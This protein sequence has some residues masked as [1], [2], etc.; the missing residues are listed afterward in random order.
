MNQ[1]NPK[2]II[3]EK[4]TQK[5]T[6]LHRSTDVEWSGILLYSVLEGDIK[7]PET[8]VLKA[9]DFYLMN[10]G[11]HSYTEFSAG[12]EIVNVYD[13]YLRLDPDEAEK[14][15]QPK[16]NMGLIHTHHGMNCFFSGTDTQ[17][18]ED[19]T[20]NYLFYLSLIVNY[21][22]QYVAKIAHQVKETGKVISRKTKLMKDNN[23]SWFEFDFI[24]KEEDL[25][26]ES[27]VSYDC[28]LLFENCL[29]LH[30]RK[31]ELLKRL[32]D[33]NPKWGESSWVRFGAVDDKR[34]GL[35]DPNSFFRKTVN[36]KTIFDDI[37]FE[38]QTSLP[39]EF[40]MSETVVTAIIKEVLNINEVRNPQTY[41]LHY[42]FRI[43]DSIK[44]SNKTL[45]NEW[46]SCLE[47]NLDLAIE[48]RVG[49]DLTVSETVEFFKICKSIVDKKDYTREYK[50]ADEFVEFINEMIEYNGSKQK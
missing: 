8:L 28:N 18:L 40:K 30:N 50:S 24:T 21:K 14:L 5:V 1:L 29:D 41:P 6:Y 13:A 10:I 46:E 47:F 2:L 37:D 16:L 12:A 27:V 25:S 11:S 45:Y 38:R 31:E 32:E 7:N 43:I 49:R 15:N 23:G 4:L 17:E 48:E 35:I 19:N 34:S 26:N 36:T 42:Y 20:K 39:L 3:S 22:G 9:E 33:S 44:H